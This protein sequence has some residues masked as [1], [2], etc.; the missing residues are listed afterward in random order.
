MT[1]ECQLILS[2]YFQS[3]HNGNS[4]DAANV[5]FRNHMQGPLKNLH[6]IVIHLNNLHNIVIH[7]KETRFINEF[8][9]CHLYKAF[10]CYVVNMMSA[11][12]VLISL[13][14][15]HFVLCNSFSLV[16]RHVS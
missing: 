6:N 16:I 14:A 4:A 7:L 3:K 11:A 10:Q 15:I 9:N 5:N 13:A 1:H 8:K 2:Y 12:T